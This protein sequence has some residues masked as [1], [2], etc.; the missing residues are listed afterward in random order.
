[1]YVYDAATQLWHERAWDVSCY[2]NCYDKHLFGSSSDGKIYS[3]SLDTFTTDGSEQIA[4]LIFPPIQIDGDRFRVN[5]VQLDMEAGVGEITTDPQVMLQT[6]KDGKTWSNE[7]WVGFGSQ[8]NNQQRA[9]WNRLGQYRTCHL[10]F[11][12][13]DPVKRA[14]YSAYA[15]MSRDAG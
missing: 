7:T 10:K 6:S 1:M 9:I 4:T 13:S 12:I 14:V 5:G 2:V 15:Q 11:S 3:G 8:G